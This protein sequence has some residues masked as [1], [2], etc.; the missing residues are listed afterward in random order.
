MEAKILENCGALVSGNKY[1][2]TIIL[3]HNMLIGTL[4]EH[5][6]KFRSYLLG[7]KMIDLSRC[8][9]LQ[10][11]VYIGYNMLENGFK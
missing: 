4:D 3:D 1:Y 5:Y 9:I 8:F 7:Q 11:Y 6:C 2:I 10:K